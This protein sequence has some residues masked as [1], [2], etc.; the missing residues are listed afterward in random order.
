MSYSETLDLTS[1]R[2]FRGLNYFFFIIKD[3]QVVKLETDKKKTDFA[4]L[5]SKV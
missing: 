2:G 1:K 4:K 5:Y 3:D